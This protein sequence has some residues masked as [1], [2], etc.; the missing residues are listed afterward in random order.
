MSTPSTSP[1]LVTSEP[2]PSQRVKALETALTGFLAA[3]SDMGEV[4][5]S[6]GWAGWYFAELLND[7]ALRIASRPT[8]VVVRAG[9]PH[10][11][12]WW[13]FTVPPVN[14]VSAATFGTVAPVAEVPA[15]QPRP[16]A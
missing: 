10:D 14:A 12:C 8:R 13:P 9:V 3:Y 16:M 15:H 11:H 5:R 6:F 7:P 1:P 2:H 4:P